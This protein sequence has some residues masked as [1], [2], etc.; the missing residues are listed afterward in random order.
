MKDIIEFQE[1][2]WDNLFE[3]FIKLKEI[4]DLWDKFLWEEYQN[5]KIREDEVVWEDDNTQNLNKE[6]EVK[7]GTDKRN[8]QVA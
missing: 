7:N 6:Q 2:N 4:E 3:K 8:R 5:Y 1:Q